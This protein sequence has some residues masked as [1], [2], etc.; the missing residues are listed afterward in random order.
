MILIENIKKLL[1]QGFRF[2]FQLQLEASICHFV[3][4]SMGVWVPNCP[5]IGHICTALAEIA[6]EVLW[7]CGETT[8]KSCG[9]V[10]WG[11]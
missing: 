1:I 6:K 11:K 3:C 4:F 10:G 2:V 7:S 5:L 9:G 8:R